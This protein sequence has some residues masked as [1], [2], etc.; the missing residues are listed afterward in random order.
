MP[1]IQSAADLLRPRLAVDRA[2]GGA[3]HVALRGAWNLRALRAEYAQLSGELTA[4]GADAQVQWDLTRVDVLDDI[5]A[6]MLWRA[7][8]RS[9]REGARMRPEHRVQIGRAHV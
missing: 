6:A 4:L 8:G 3:C 1:P 9:L 2:T 5:G 7:W